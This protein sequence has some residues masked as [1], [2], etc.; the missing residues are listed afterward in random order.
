M[1]RITLNS[2]FCAAIAVV[3]ALNWTHT[4][5]T[6][7]WHVALVAL[8]VA[9][10]ATLLVYWLQTSVR[11]ASPYHTHLA[12]LLDLLDHRY[13]KCETLQLLGKYL[14]RELQDMRQEPVDC[15][16]ITRYL[17]LPRAAIAL[18]SAALHATTAGTIEKIKEFV[19]QVAA[20]NCQDGTIYPADLGRALYRAID[21]TCKSRLFNVAYP[22]V[23]A[24]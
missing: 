10:L 7:K 24:S 22:P 1:A 17:N 11:P 6:L 23:V 20:D 12:T 16:Q 3:L 4:V 21:Q 5:R 18:P 9:A 2:V 8:A 19:D 15:S 14:G 13:R